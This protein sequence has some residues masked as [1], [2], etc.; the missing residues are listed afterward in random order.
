M[1]VRQCSSSVDEKGKTLFNIITLI[2]G[3]LMKAQTA[4]IV[5]SSSTNQFPRDKLI[6]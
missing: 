6:S 3:G 2:V 4:G 5:G 1:L